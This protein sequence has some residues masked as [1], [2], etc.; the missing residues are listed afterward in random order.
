MVA[1]FWAD[2]RVRGCAARMLAGA[3]CGGGGASGAESDGSDGDIE[4]SAMAKTTPEATLR[5][6][7]AFVGLGDRYWTA[8]VCLFHKARRL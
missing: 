6:H 2:P 7:F 3:A 5:E 8:S 1:D 4:R